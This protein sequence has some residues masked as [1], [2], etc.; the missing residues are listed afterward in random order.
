MNNAK[1]FL[2]YAEE[3][4]RIAATLP[5]AQKE[6]LLTIAKAWEEAAKAAEAKEQSQGK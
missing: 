6:R 2:E 5:H 1:R 3:C 4:R